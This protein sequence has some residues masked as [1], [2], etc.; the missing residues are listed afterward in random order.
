MRL[1]ILSTLALLPTMAVAQS[2]TQTLA[3]N[4]APAPLFHVAA[5]APAPAGDSIPTSVSLHDNA[6]PQLTHVVGRVLPAQVASD[7]VVDVIV[8]V[9]PDGKPAAMRIS[10]SGGAALDQS[11][12]DAVRQFR[13]QPATVNHQ[14]VAANVNLEFT[15]SK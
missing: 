6:V 12:L 14:A 5:P 13:F 11:T 10:R 8:T 3:A 9:D 7:K 15:L 2:G 1:L 4:S